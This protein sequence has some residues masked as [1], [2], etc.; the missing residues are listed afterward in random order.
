[1]FWVVVPKDLRIMALISLFDHM[2]SAGDMFFCAVFY[3]KSRVVEALPLKANVFHIAL[4]FTR[5]VGMECWLGERF[6]RSIFALSG[7]LQ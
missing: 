4:L 2:V 1:M 3:L 6:R 5:T 7:F